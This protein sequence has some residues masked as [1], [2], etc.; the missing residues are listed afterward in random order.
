[1]SQKFSLYDHPSQMEPLLPA[2]H[3]LGPLLELAHVLIRQADRLVGGYQ[4][5]ALPALR[6]LLRAMNSYYTNK[7][8]GQHTL[9][10]SGW[11]GFTL[12]AMATVGWRA[13]TRTC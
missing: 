8:G 7:I 11:H 6:R 2:E 4:A 3:R 5:G 9:P 12:F 10:I 13:C 1:M